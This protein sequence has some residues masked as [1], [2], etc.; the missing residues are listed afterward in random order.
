MANDF[1]LDNNCLVLYRFENGALTTDSKDSA[2]LVA[3]SPSPTADTTH[4][5]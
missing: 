2:T 5:K 4:Y 1:S 3:S